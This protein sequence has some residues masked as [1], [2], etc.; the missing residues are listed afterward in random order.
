MAAYGLA[1]TLKN[2]K[3]NRP[4]YLFP[5]LGCIISSNKFLINDTHYHPL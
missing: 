2:D 3:K 4:P 5:P 1:R